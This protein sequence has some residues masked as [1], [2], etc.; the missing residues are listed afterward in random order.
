MGFDG[1]QEKG[2]TGLMTLGAWRVGHEGDWSGQESEGFADT[3]W[4]F[5]LL[6]WVDSV[7]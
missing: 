7:E 4:F 6:S 1:G 5:C 3:A 2:F